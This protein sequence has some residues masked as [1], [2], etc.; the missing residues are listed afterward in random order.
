M[1]KILVPA[2]LIFVFSLSTAAQ[3]I[4]QKLGDN[5]I[6]QT[7]LRVAISLSEKLMLGQK[8]GN[9]Y[10]LSEDE[11]IP[12]VAKGLTKDIQTSSY[13]SVSAMFGAY[14]SMQFSEA[15]KTESDQIYTIYRFR[16]TFS[17]SSDKPEIRIVFDTETKVAGFF[18]LPWDADFGGQP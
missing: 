4:F 5:E 6:S 8:T 14:E 17:A 15:W 3:K 18:I 16:G 7:E 11:A 12:Q 1:K 9:I 2:V 13:E 10:I